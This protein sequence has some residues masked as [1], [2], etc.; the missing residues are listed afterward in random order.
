MSLR[1][2][3]TVVT[4]Q[5]APIGG[6]VCSLHVST[7]GWLT[8]VT[9]TD[10]YVLWPEVD[11]GLTDSDLKITAHDFLDYLAHVTLPAGVNYQF[12]VPDAQMPPLTPVIPALS[13]LH[14]DGID[15]RD[16][17]G[18]RV[19]LAEVTNFLQFYRFIRGEDLTP[20]RYPGFDMDR[21]TLTM[22]YVPAQLGW[23]PLDPDI[24]GW[25]GY[26]K[27]F[28]QFLA[29]K[30]SIG[31]RTELTYLCDMAPMGKSLVWQ[32]KFVSACSEVAQP[33]GNVNLQ[34]LGNEVLDG[35][36]GVNPHD[37]ADL[38]RRGLIWSSGSSL[39][40]EPVP[41]PYWDYCTPHLVRAPLFK[42][43]ADGNFGEQVYGEWPAHPVPT[44]RP[45]LVNEMKGADETRHDN[46]RSNDPQEFRELGR[47]VASRNG[48]CLHSSLGVYSQPLGPVQ[49][50]CA[51][52]FL[53]GIRGG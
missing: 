12:A 15:F 22:S 52:A 31:R 18:T 13:P 40:G 24:L 20:T 6:A 11:G 16:A 19:V 1:A 33:Y 38:D 51:A 10:G 43:L 42:E 23:T 2:V 17:A 45:M 26:L 9:K 21:V 30:R 53:E 46:D 29:Y 37:F 36:N 28:D 27:V 7:S 35:D 3:A 32:K 41:E 34:E 4:F 39:S 44:H 14:V 5:G 49:Q 25:P 48:G 50:Q 47:I 8:A